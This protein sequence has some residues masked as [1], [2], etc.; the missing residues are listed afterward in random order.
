MSA[1]VETMFYVSNEAN[2]R[3]VPWHGLGNPVENA[4]NSKEAI[5]M[6]GL[7]WTVDSHPV[8][9]HNGKVI[10]GY[11]ANTRSNDDSVLGI[12]S[13]R[14]KIVQNVD[15]FNFTD[16]LIGDEV[17]YETAGSLKSG[18]CVWLLA[19]LP[20]TQ[21]LGDK[22][23]P[24]IC[25]TNSHDGTG[26]IKACL[27][28]IRVVCNNTLNIALSTASRSWSVRHVGDINGKLEEARTTLGLA[29]DYMKAFDVEA[30]RLASIKISE[31]EVNKL[32]DKVFPVN[33]DTDSL[34]KI[35]NA[36][37]MRDEFF[38][39]YNM[40]DIANFKGTQYGI[41]NAMTDM[42]GHSTP[43]RLTSKYQENNW[44][45]IMNGHP[46]VDTTYALLNA[47]A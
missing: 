21:I 4:L 30:E 28:N 14:Y 5:E 17:H 34:R 32:L 9:D 20:E 43:A 40:D 19:K 44:G 29:N 2:Q 22:F 10:P 41:I 18:K 42:V 13:N 24:Y 15:A 27:T 11:V 6:A 1:N 12:V 35:R 39:C 36:Q 16:S 47:A 8:F 45:K 38:R 37:E 3:F 7:D 25:F 46:I 31:N 23:V 26:A 33:Y